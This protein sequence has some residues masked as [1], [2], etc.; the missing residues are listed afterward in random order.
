MG[1]DHVGS[2]LVAK[3]PTTADRVDGGTVV[4]DTLIYVKKSNRRQVIPAAYVHSSKCTIVVVKTSTAM[5]S[6]PKF[7]Q[8]TDAGNPSTAAA[9]V[10]TRRGPL[11]GV[12]ALPPA[13]VADAAAVATPAVVTATI[14]VVGAVVATS[15]AAVD[16]AVVPPPV[17]APPVEAPPAADSVAAAL[18]AVAPPVAPPV[19]AVLAAGAL[20]EGQSLG[21]HAELE[22]EYAHGFVRV[23]AELQ[24]GGSGR[25]PVW[26]VTGVA[27]DSEWPDDHTRV[28]M[29]GDKLKANNCALGPPA[30]GW[31][32]APPLGDGTSAEKAVAAARTTAAAVTAAAAE[33]GGEAVDETTGAAEGAASVV[34]VSPPT[35]LSK[36]RHGLILDLDRA[37]ALGVVE[38]KCSPWDPQTWANGSSSKFEND[39]YIVVPTG[40]TGNIKMVMPEAAAPLALSQAVLKTMA[41]NPLVADPRTMLQLRKLKLSAFDGE[42]SL[43]VVN[44]VVLTG[45]IDS[46]AYEPVNGQ[47]RGIG[48]ERSTDGVMTGE[49]RCLCNGE[50]FYVALIMGVVDSAS[51][52]FTQLLLGYNYC[53]GSAAVVSRTSVASH[54]YAF[55]R[56]LDLMPAPTLEEHHRMIGLCSLLVLSPGQLNDGNTYQCMSMATCWAGEKNKYPF[57]PCSKAGRK[58]TLKVGESSST[59]RPKTDAVSKVAAKAAKGALKAAKATESRRSAK[60]LARS[61]SAHPA[62][63]DTKVITITDLTPKRPCVGDRQSSF[64]AYHSH[65]QAAREDA[66]LKAVLEAKLAAVSE[67]GVVEAEAARQKEAVV[68]LEEARAREDAWRKDH[69]AAKDTTDRHYQD[70]LRAAHT[71]AFSFSLALHNG[72]CA[73]PTP[74]VATEL[75]GKEALFLELLTTVDCEQHFKLLWDHGVKSVNGIRM[76]SPGD[77]MKCGLN[78][79]E[80]RMLKSVVVE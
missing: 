35:L 69:A 7:V 72:S 16:T 19:A 39:S 2:V 46:R 50:H 76:V 80:V 43:D 33:G 48:T 10:T 57:T 68:R 55:S 21:D 3:I 71:E 1:F 4:P 52:P 18:A 6:E 64:P 37:F 11:G 78:E 74:V 40:G 41:A 60:P 26:H 54:A 73:L 61:A 23:N 45:I 14:T 15:A 47:P 13:T 34:R 62:D 38:N 79:F 29:M 22:M 66:I 56:G 63:V 27:D 53:T 36:L 65:S 70:A 51:S 8:T 30:P 24:N 59:K 5:A 49:N 25:Y 17:E 28:S 12:A 75:K 9:V 58:P 42:L 20:A 67:L 32:L 44:T 77:L 31:R